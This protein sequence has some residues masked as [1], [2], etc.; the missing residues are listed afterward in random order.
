MAT[1]SIGVPIVLN[2]EMADK[3]FDAMERPAKKIH[4]E[5]KTIEHCES[6]EEVRELIEKVKKCYAKK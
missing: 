2:D 3:I 5:N 6:R 1:S 4:I